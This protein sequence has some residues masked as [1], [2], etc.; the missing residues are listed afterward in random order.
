MF[1]LA[2]SQGDLVPNGSGG[3]LLVYDL[4]LDRQD[5]A[6]RAL[7]NNPDQ[8]LWPL[9]ANLE[10]LIGKPNNAVTGTKA[11]RQVANALT[12]DGRFLIQNL[13]IQSTPITLSEIEIAVTINDAVIPSASTVYTTIIDLEG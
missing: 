7:T 9:G 11:E 3:L 8:L 12:Y 10:D 13:L 1:D 5:C 4:D 2:F 6:Y